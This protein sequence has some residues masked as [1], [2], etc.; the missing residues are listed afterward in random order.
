MATATFVHDGASIDHTPS[1]AVTAGDVIVQGDLIG[2]AKKDIAAAAL[3]A[4][5]TVG[6]YDFPKSTA[7][8]SAITAGQTL[9]WDEENEVA[10]PTAGANKRIGPAVSAATAAATTVRALLCPPGV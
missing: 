5:A 3:G 1:S 8:T 10:T 4:L 6:V 9:Y 7:S 2:I